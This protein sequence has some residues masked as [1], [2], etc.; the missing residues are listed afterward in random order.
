MFR[1]CQILDE[2]IRRGL[3]IRDNTNRICVPDRTLVSPQ[4]APGRNMKDRIDNWHK[5]H[6]TST[7]QALANIIEVAPRT[8]DGP[9]SFEHSVLA[10]R[11]DEDELE[12]LEAVALATARRQEE[13][14]K[15]LGNVHKGKNAPNVPNTG[16]QRSSNSVPTPAPP[17]NTAPQYRFS[18][19]IEDPK[20]IHDVIQ[21]SLEGTI[22]LTQRELYAIAPD[23][24]KH[25]KD[26]VTTHRIPS[27]PT[28]TASTIEN[29]DPLVLAHHQ[30]PQS[31]TNRVVVANNI[32]ELRTI[33]L[34]LD[35]RYTV[36]A[37]LDEGSQI[38]GIRRDVWEKLGL[39]LLKDLNMVM[40]SANATKDTTLGLLHDLPVRIGNSIFYLQVQVFENA[41][42][43]MLLGRP[44][45][46]LTQAQTHH[47]S[48]GDSHI[49]ILDPNTNESFT[50]PT[51][52][53][54]RNQG[55]SGF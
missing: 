6:N 22:T 41:P 5:T 11:Q 4:I 34:E 30:H 27:A 46:T 3:C 28:A 25:I 20:A 37:I 42:Y 43:E 50:I 33:P 1:F 40:E 32:E 39:P 16:N 29:G 38:I 36:D 26:Q 31:S 49:T 45:L 54:I 8:N 55:N 17:A 14:R 2:Y 51:A 52:A 15:K 44:F 24:R 13:I 48:N 53:R 23:V 7:P 10:L 18:S 47:Y 9:S 35:G 21:R 19:A 12:H